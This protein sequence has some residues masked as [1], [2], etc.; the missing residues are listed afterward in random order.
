[1]TVFVGVFLVCV[2]LAYRIGVPAYVA[3]L[4]AM[5]MLD[6]LAVP[7]PTLLPLATCAPA[8]GSLRYVGLALLACAALAALVTSGCCDNSSRYATVREVVEDLALVRC[9][10]ATECGIY[11][12]EQLEACQYAYTEGACD[13]LDCNAA[14]EGRDEDVDRCLNALSL[15]PCGLGGAPAECAP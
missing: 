8:P 13:D 12:P 4:A 7:V 6:A 11:G 1:M 3:L 2:P 10:V 15:W 5:A 9:Q 14:F